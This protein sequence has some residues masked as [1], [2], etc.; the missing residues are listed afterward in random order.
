MKVLKF[1]KPALYA[2]CVSMLGIAPQGLAASAKGPALPN[3]ITTTQGKTYRSVQFV[4]ADPEG[5]TI[6]YKP[7]AGGV[8][9]TR[10]KFSNLPQKIGQEFNYSA[11]AAAQYEA[12]QRKALDHWAQQLRSAQSRKPQETAQPQKDPSA[13][14]EEQAQPPSAGYQFPSGRFQVAGTIR[15]AIIVDTVTGEAWMADLHS[16][17]G[18][19]DYSHFLEPKVELPDKAT[20]GPTAVLIG[21]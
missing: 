6:E 20:A 5:L 10:L 4:S 11:D 13:A 21:P 12:A 1:T 17:L 3:T 9:M 2:V 7:Q 18:Y 14:Y 8:G 16:T 19:Y 15:G